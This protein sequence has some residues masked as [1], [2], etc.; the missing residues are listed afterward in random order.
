MA[1]D[2]KEMIGALMRVLD[3]G[4]ITQTEVEELEFEGEDALQEALDEAY[5]RL[6]EFAHDR[7]MRQSDAEAD[8]AMRASLQACLDKIWRRAIAQA[9]SVT[10]CRIDL[11]GVRTMI[12]ASSRG[13]VSQSEEPHVHYCEARSS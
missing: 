13:P 7:D 8:R 11:G 1:P 6:L 4:E 3:G 5:I 2:V 12:G 10:P 9:R